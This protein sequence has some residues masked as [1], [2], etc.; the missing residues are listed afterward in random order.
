MKFRVFITDNAMNEMSVSLSV[1][2]KKSCFGGSFQ[3]SSFDNSLSSSSKELAKRAV[4]KSYK[5]I[6][7][8]LK[9]GF[10]IALISLA[11]SSAGFLLSAFAIALTL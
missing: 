6:L 1:K 8:V 11:I 10:I 4:V 2:G 9:K 7:K 5:K 3:Y